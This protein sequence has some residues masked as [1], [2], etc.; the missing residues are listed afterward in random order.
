MPNRLRAEALLARW[1]EAER[2]HASTP[3]GTPEFEATRREIVEVRRNFQ[4]VVEEAR[5]LDLAHL[6]ERPRIPEPAE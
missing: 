5:E 3:P 1:R 2:R 6:A 4:Q